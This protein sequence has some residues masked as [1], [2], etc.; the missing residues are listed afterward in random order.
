MA[1]KKRLLTRFTVKRVEKYIRSLLLLPLLLWSVGSLAEC[2][3]DIPSTTLTQNFRING[4]GTVS[5]LSTGLMWR[6][7][8]GYTS[9]NSEECLDTRAMNTWQETLQG[10]K[11][12]NDEGGFAGYTDWR[13][14]N[15]KELRTIVDEA[16]SHANPL[17]F[18]NA[19]GEHWTST[20]VAEDLPSD[21]DHIWI[22]YLTD[23]FVSSL[24]SDSLAPVM[25]VRD[26]D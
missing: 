21:D 11:Q 16:C 4:D 2:S 22:V 18:P 20:H 23:G 12:L 9:S 7:C 17:L 1:M 5:D 26:E 24:P 15:V 13:L 10:T 14:P 19:Q 3:P 25:L 8:S 6:K